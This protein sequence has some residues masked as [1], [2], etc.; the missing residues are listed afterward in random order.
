M[1][2]RGRGPQDEDDAE[3]GVCS[4]PQWKEVAD[5]GKGEERLLTSLEEEIMEEEAD[6]E[7]TSVGMVGGRSFGVNLLL[8]RFPAGAGD[9]E[10]EGG[11]GSAF[12]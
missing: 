4:K 8:C 2:K 6:E 5:A 11:S 7:R 9:S 1:L 12:E 10:E 3:D